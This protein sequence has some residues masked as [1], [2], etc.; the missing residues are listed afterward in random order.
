MKNWISLNNVILHNRR[1][2]V[3]KKSDALRPSSQYLQR[4]LHRWSFVDEAIVQINR[5]KALYFNTY[6]QQKTDAKGRASHQ[7]LYRYVVLSTTRCD[8][9]RAY[10]ACKEVDKKN[11]SPSTH[12]YITLRQCFL[13]TSAVNDSLSRLTIY[14][15]I[16][17]LIVI[18]C[19][20]DAYKCVLCIV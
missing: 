19:P 4:V 9:E 18:L 13:F 17:M 14:N 12:Q 1:V 11:A 5:S 8:R 20:Q 6:L 16:I 7:I 10:I 2:K 3:I 15:D